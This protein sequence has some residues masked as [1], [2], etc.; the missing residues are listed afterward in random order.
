MADLNPIEQIV[1]KA[2]EE[3]GAS[4]ED[5]MKTADDIMKKC[6]RPKGQISNA[7]M[8]MVSKGVIARKVRE[9]ASGYY[10]IKKA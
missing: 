6:N 7:L 5:K 3:I 4:S 2:M 1:L 8:S 9:K 10:I